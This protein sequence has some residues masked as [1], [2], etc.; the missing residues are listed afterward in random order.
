MC[1]LHN[2]LPQFYGAVGQSRRTYTRMTWY[3]VV[4]EAERDEAARGCDYFL[5]GIAIILN[6][7]FA[8]V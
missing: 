6:G 3:I 5:R 8:V 1:T 2:K 7:R 4:G